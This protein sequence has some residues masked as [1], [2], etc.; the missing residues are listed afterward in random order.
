MRPID[1]DKLIEE[2]FSIS[3]AAVQQDGE[4]ELLVPLSAVVAAIRQAPTVE[5]GVS[6]DSEDAGHETC[7]Q[8]R[9][10][11]VG[12]ENVPRAK[13]PPQAAE[14]I[15]ASIAEQLT[16]FLLCEDKQPEDVRVLVRYPGMMAMVE[17]RIRL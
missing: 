1:A 5:S 8:E 10:R 16:H 9:G 2:R 11:G 17:L 15:K 4:G 6:E 12:T 7:P 14:R 3:P 13:A